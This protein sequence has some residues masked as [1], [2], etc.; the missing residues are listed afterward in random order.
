MK[1]YVVSLRRDTERRRYIEGHLKSRG[2]EYEIVDAIDYQEMTSDDFAASTDEAAVLSN[3]FFTKGVQA[4][5]LSH[6]KIYSLI[7]AS[8]D[9]AALLIEDDIVLAPNIKSLLAIIEK[10]IATEEI[11]SLSYYS[12]GQNPIKFSLLDPRIITEQSTLFYPTNLDDI[13]AA[14]AYVMTPAVATKM[15]AATLPVRVPADAWG[16]H[17]RNGAFTSFRC[18][19]PKPVEP[20]IFPSTLDYAATIQSPAR[21]QLTLLV[22]KVSAIVRRKRIPFLLQYLDKR[23]KKR[24]DNKSAIRFV[25]TSPFNTF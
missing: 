1:V 15:L 17:Y 10:E 22:N 25:T 19:Y 18:L 7:A 4:C 13:A 9:K 8:S 3:P 16:S 14:M 24:M 2:L 20:A 6:A 23:N 11:I 12:H 5:A 21:Q